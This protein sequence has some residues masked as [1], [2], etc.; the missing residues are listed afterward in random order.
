MFDT[1]LII[2]VLVAYMVLLFFMAMGVEKKFAAQSGIVNNALVYSLSLT[3][4]CTTWAYYGSIGKA[5]TSGMLFVTFFLGPTLAFILGWVILRKL[6]RI[7]T[8]RKITSIAD[9]I[10]ARY[11]KSQLIAAIVTSIAL[12]GISPYIALQL[13]SL[14]STFKII[15]ASNNPDILWLQNHTGI[16]IVVTLITFTILFGVRRLDPTERHPGIIF[17]IAVEAIVKLVV[18]L[19]AGIFTTYFMYNGFGDIFNQA[20]ERKL[21][22]FSGNDSNYYVIWMTSIILSMSACIFLPR[23]FHVAVVENFNENHIKTAMWFFPLYLFLINIF[24]LPVALAGLLKGYSI[25]EADTFLLSLPVSVGHK[26]ISLLVFLGGFSAGTGMIMICSMTLAT[27]IINHL[28]LPLTEYIKTLS[29]LKRHILKCRWVAVAVVILL[30]YWFELKIGNSYMLV[31]IGTISFAA[32]IQF[33]PSIIGGIF[34]DRGNKTGAL[35]GLLSGFFIW[36]YTLLLPSFIKSGWLS[37]TIL[38]EGPYGIGLLRP[39]NLLGM[40]ALDPLSHCVFWS[41]FFN[42]G[43]YVLSSLYFKQSEEEYKEAIE[44]V[45]ILNQN[46]AA[47]IFTGNKTLVDLK[48]KTNILENL[49]SEYFSTS[50]TVEIIGTVFSKFG[51]T[52]KEKISLENLADIYSE[53]EKK[54][55]GIIGSPSAH[56]AMKKVEIFTQD[57]S[58]ELTELYTETIAELKIT[59]EE[60]KKKIDYYRE[61]QELLKNH[62]MELEKKIKE[63]EAEIVLR[64][65][66]EEEVKQLNEELEQRVA[67]RTSELEGVNKE[68]KAFAYSISHDLRAPLRSIDGFSLILLEDYENKMYDEGKDYLQRIRSNSQKMATLI[69]HIL[70]LSQ[71]AYMEISLKQV[72]LSEMAKN[73]LD[74]LKHN[75]RERS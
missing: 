43:L 29:F 66:V 46:S 8:A 36:F 55:A 42:I 53:F 12:I 14:I 57:E 21:L 23:Q 64:K 47:R 38:K 50:Q 33:A 40:T 10:S 27:M 35:L 11:G 25:H 74:D 49:L 31:N 3:V 24:V 62:S 1:V 70:K 56:M 41:L 54:M 72:N 51:L 32:V 16:I 7:K 19:I 34:W 30:G 60:L 67:R 44:F 71:V 48:S 22:L 75:D 37:E 58:R 69:E 73:I 61:K 20:V 9:F 68:L 52:G 45:N 6:I 65:K 59:P 15:T 39:E 4:Y 17:I 26:W 13:K 2:I 5:A 28:I 63:R 18:F